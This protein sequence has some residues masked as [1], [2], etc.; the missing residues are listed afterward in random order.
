MDVAA[1]LLK[2]GEGA[3]AENWLEWATGVGFWEEA[4]DQELTR[5]AQGWSEA[6]GR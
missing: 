6:V 5:T 4:T 3:R 1:G 2:A